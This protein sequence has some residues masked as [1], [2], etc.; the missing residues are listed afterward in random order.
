MLEL[1]PKCMTFWLIKDCRKQEKV[2]PTIEGTNIGYSFFWDFRL[3]VQG[4]RYK[5]TAHIITSHLFI[6]RYQT[7]QH[8][9]YPREGDLDVGPAWCHDAWYVDLIHPVL[10]IDDCN[11]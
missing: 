2:F 3:V 7:K 9:K 11:I 10:I 8:F 4:A 1:I 5:T 6:Q